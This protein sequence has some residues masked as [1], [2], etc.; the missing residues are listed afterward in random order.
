MVSLENS[1]LTVLGSKLKSCLQEAKSILK[2]AS[3]VRNLKLINRSLFKCAPNT[4]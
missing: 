3:K 1:K 2:N 4:D